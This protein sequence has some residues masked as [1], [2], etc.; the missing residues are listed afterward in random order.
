MG[1]ADIQSVDRKSPSRLSVLTYEDQKL[2]LG[3]DKV[4]DFE[5]LSP[6]QTFS[7]RTLSLISGQ[8]E[9]TGDRSRDRS[10]SRRVPGPGQA[11]AHSRRL[12]RHALFRTGVHR[13]RQR[14]LVGFEEMEKGSGRGQ[15]SGPRNGTSWR[16]G[17]SKRT[18]ATSTRCGS[19][20]FSSRSLWIRHTMRNFAVRCRSLCKRGPAPG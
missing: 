9:E 2:R 16:S 17:P 12:R 1:L 13:L 7:D 11:Q 4:F 10:D 8:A 14:G 3:Q 20:A 15:T 5:L 6:D 18:A 19:F